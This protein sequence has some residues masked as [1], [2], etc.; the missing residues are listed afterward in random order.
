MS[1]AKAFLTEAVQVVAILP[2]VRT[3]GNLLQSAPGTFHPG[4]LTRKVLGSKT[5]PDISGVYEQK[6]R[7]GVLVM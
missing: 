4:F 2:Y 1:L 7:Q 6:Y 3:A 5:L